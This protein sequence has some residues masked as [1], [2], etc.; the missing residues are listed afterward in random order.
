MSSRRAW[1]LIGLGA[2]LLGLS[3]P[4]FRLPIVS[5]IAIAPAVLLVRQAVDESNPRRAFRWGF[6]YGLASQGLV[7]YWLVVALW[8]FT[9]LSACAGS[10][11]SRNPSFGWTSA[12][13]PTSRTGSVRI[14]QAP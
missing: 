3:C 5:F 7:L 1:L 9:P 2:L 13:T 10:H 6:W 12:T 8:H 11:F 14:R 4:P